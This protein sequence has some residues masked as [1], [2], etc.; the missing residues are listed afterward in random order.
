LI[1]LKGGGSFG[2]DIEMVTQ[3]FKP[4]GRPPFPVV[5]FSHGRAADAIDRAKLVRPVPTSQVRYW[6]SKG[7]A[8]VAPIRP[9]YGKTGGADAEN[10][11]TSF[12]ASGQCRSRP[13][14]STTA[15][16]GKKAVR[17]TLE[18]LPSQAWADSHKVILVGQSVGG[19]VTVASGAEHFEGVL[20]Y[21]NFAG[22][23]GGNP[24]RS[25]GRSCGPEQL[26]ALYA[27][28]GKATTVPNLWIYAE[29]DQ[30][31]GPEVPKEWHAAFA[32]GGSPTRFVHAPPVPDGNGHGLSGHA[33]S[34]WAP[35]LEPFI[36]S[37]R[38]TP[39]AETPAATAP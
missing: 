33:Q 10:S 35:Y 8:V 36:S 5:V 22:G 13:V 31:W 27:E 24:A 26:T 3:L 9:G 17:A 14:F 34:L 19:L 28:A 12:D 39:A 23:S 20:G 7:F 18:W 6:L 29:N 30:Y 16:A 11:G 38:I 1:G 32:A 15:D 25:P 2:G 21:I 37:L 4:E